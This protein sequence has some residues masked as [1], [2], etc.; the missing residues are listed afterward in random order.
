MISLASVAAYAEQW[1]GHSYS[2]EPL[3]LIELLVERDE[4]KGEC[5]KATERLFQFQAAAIDL[6]AKLDDAKALVEKYAATAE[7]ATKQAT[8]CLDRAEAAKAQVAR[9]RAALEDIARGDYSDPFC[10]RTPEERARAGLSET[11][12]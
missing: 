1:P 5:N 6:S 7:T 9:L 2:V 3:E 12:L 8:R 4:L 11:A 10:M